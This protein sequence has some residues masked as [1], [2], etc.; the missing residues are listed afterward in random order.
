MCLQTLQRAYD[1]AVGLELQHMRERK[2]VFKKARPLG[3]SSS[4]KE[5]RPGSSREQKDGSSRGAHAQ[6]EI[7]SKK[8]Q[9]SK[10]SFAEDEEEEP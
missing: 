4:S 10:L 8:Q 3:G 1:R 7:G 6:G 9:K 2:H 5:H